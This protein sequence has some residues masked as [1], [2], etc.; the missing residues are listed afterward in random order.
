M[1]RGMFTGTGRGS[2]SNRLTAVELVRPPWHRSLWVQIPLAIWRWS[3]EITLA[4]ALV[5]VWVRLHAVMPPYAAV[6]VLVVPVAIAANV[7]WLRRFLQGC[8]WVLVVRHRLRTAC[9]Q[10]GHSNRSGKLPWVVGW[11]PTPV[12]ERVWLL[13]VAG[14]S[15]PDL[16]NS[17]DALAAACFARQVRITARRANSAWVRVDVIRHD[18]LESNNPVGSRLMRLLDR[19]LPTKPEPQPQHPSA[20]EPLTDLFNTE[21]ASARPA[22]DDG[23]ISEYV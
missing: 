7:P 8:F 20:N 5:V 12:G 9:V 23:G 4:V 13:L 6:S 1:A 22:G 11:W 16:D 19:V 17:A 14:L 18:P 2:S 3:I 10:L 21:P 15:A